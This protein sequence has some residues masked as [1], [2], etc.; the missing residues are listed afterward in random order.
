MKKILIITYY[1]PPQGGVGVQRWLKLTKYLAKSGYKPIIY[2]SKDGVVPLRD[3]SLLDCIDPNVHIIKQKIFEPQKIFSFFR[4]HTFGSDILI[5]KSSNFLDKILI[6]I[7]ANFFIP[8]SRCF[9]IKP[10]INFLLKYL[11]KNPVDVIIST[12]PP[13]SMHMIA[14]GIKK[15]NP[16]IKWIADFRDPWTGIEYFDNLPLMCFAKKRHYKLEKKIVSNNDL[17]LSV[18]PT[19]EKMFIKIGAQKTYVLPNGYDIEDYDKNN[20]SKEKD[21]HGFL[22]GHFGL[23][24]KLRDHGFL[25]KILRDIS[26]N[27]VAFSRNLKLLFAGE[28]HD[29]FIPQLKNYKLHNQMDHFPYLA[30]SAAIKHMMTCDLLLVTQADT[31]SVLGRL[32]AKFFEYIGAR[33][34]ILVIG[35]KNSDLEEITSKI[36]CAWFVDIGNEELLYSTILHIYNMRTSYNHVD[37]DTSIFSRENQAKKLIEIIHDI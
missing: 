18:S 8:D 26:D 31:T 36:S 1:W 33:R 16:H 37:D 20:F 29:S 27:N 30:H 25:W 24:N 19:W 21:D 2:T 34:P 35:K 12:G 10:S 4:K 5:K 13:H 6:W 14:L 7:R 15:M 17:L 11:N 22:I 23:Y 9:W 32:P 3:D 28:V